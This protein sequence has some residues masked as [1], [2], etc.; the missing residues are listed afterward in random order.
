MVPKQF[1][2]ADSGARTREQPTLET[3]GRPVWV[4]PARGFRAWQS[5][6]WQGRMEGGIQQPI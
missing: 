6:A 2:M 5:V 4:N 1:D 3:P